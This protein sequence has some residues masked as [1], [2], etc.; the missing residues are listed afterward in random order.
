MH[1]QD[2]VNNIAALKLAANELFRQR[3]FAGALDVYEKLS[4]LLPK[5]ASFA[6]RHAYCYIALR[7]WPQART[8]WS[9]VIEIHGVNVTRLN[10]IAQCLVEMQDFS[11]AITALDAGRGRVT[12]NASDFVYHSI[13]SLAVGDLDRALGSAL[14]AQRLASEEKWL[15]V[16]DHFAWLLQRLADF[17]VGVNVLGFLDR[18]LPLVE[19]KGRLL[20]VGVDIATALR[21]YDIKLRYASEMVRLAP[22]AVEGYVH[23]MYAQLEAGGYDECQELLA[24]VNAR[25]PKAGRSEGD[26][27][28]IQGVEMQLPSWKAWRQALDSFDYVETFQS[29][30]FRVAA[31]LTLKQFDKA[32]ELASRA[33]EKIDD[34]HPRFMVLLGKSYE[35]L[36]QLDSALDWFKK[37]SE[38]EPTSQN[39]LIHV[40]KLQLKLGLREAAI[41]TISLALRQHPN[42]PILTELAER[43]EWHVSDHCTPD[44]PAPSGDSPQQA[45]WLHGGDSGDVIYALAAMRAAGGGHLYLTGFEGTREPMNDSKIQFLA[46]L[47]AAQP[48]IEGVAMWGGEPIQRD[49]TAFRQRMFRDTDLATQQWQSVLSETEPDVKTAW[50]SVPPLAKHG[51]P[52]FARSQRYQNRNWEPFWRELKTSS[53]DAIFVGT[54]AEFDEFRHGELCFARDALDLAQIINGASIFV[55]NQS[56]PFALAEGLKVGRILEPCPYLQNCTFPGALALGFARS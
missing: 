20:K 12:A 45:S 47:L 25:F 33:L 8:L 7:R 16:N 19:V 1:E 4:I 52:V 48:Y 9:R 11:A 41:H 55:G 46:P 34:S 36:G 21:R 24:Q 56:L 44:T 40:F 53:P 51:R 22:A 35:G 2:A 3:D 50:L 14:E 28:R 37:A 10:Y 43:L 39:Y 6:D 31:L 13:A 49:F 15:T 54:F 27:E 23:Q 30:N 18:L 5:D 29:I 26:E 38:R 17:G 32:A 42:M